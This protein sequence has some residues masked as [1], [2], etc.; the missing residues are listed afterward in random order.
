M[1][2]QE[3]PDTP[4][5][6][7][8]ARQAAYEAALGPPEHHFRPALGAP[9][10]GVA[11]FPPAQ[12]RPFYTFATSGMSDFPQLLADGSELRTELL[13]C[14]REESPLVANLLHT[15]ALLPFREGSAFEP[16]LARLLPVGLIRGGFDGVLLAASRLTP[17]LRSLELGP[18]R[19]ELLAVIP[20]SGAELRRTGRTS[21]AELLAALPDRLDTW[22]LDGRFSDWLRPPMERGDAG[23]DARSA[24]G[25]PC[26]TDAVS[27]PCPRCG[28]ELRESRIS[29]QPDPF[30]VCRRCGWSRRESAA[31]HA[32]AYG[33]AV[34]RC[35]AAFGPESV[36]Y[37][38]RPGGEGVVV[39]IVR[40][41]RGPAIVELRSLV[42]D[43]NQ[44]ADPERALEAKL[45]AVRRA[46]DLETG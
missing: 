13:A 11:R 45:A 1:V 5:D 22:L 14:C 40:P 30:L 32:E 7:E 12:G 46:F 26:L 35:R 33:W 39:R 36:D 43:I 17:G 34:E 19:V 18:D 4:L 15:L 37:D 21:A 41:G 27:A 38:V 6:Y 25:S 9:H 23:A 28:G 20:I 44:T 2:L 10:V 31:E 42:Y 24:G 8:A 16:P 29:E 3:H